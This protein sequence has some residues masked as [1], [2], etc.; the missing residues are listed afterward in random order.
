MCSDGSKGGCEGCAPSLGV[1]ILSISCSF[2]ENLANSY[3]GPPLGSLRPLL[4]E[5]LDPPLMWIWS[6][7]FQSNGILWRHF[8][9]KEDRSMWIWRRHFQLSARRS[10][11]SLPPVDAE[12]LWSSRRINPPP[13]RGSLDR[14]P[15][16]I[17]TLI[18]KQE[19]IP[20]G[21]VP[22][23]CKPHVL[24]RPPPDVASGDGF[25]KRSLVLAT[26]CQ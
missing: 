11:D 5:I 13:P 3:V 4:G 1:Q 16:E 6:R 14:Q 20:I 15:K 25:G 17:K 2:W 12:N 23:A 19:S 9:W 21:C 18:Y 7:H 24:Q 10:R 22:P 26:R 8:R